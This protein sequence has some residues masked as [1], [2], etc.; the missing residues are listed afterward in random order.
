MVKDLGSI[1]E[2][3]L[4]KRL[5]VALENGHKEAGIP[6]I[7][8]KYGRNVLE[9]EEQESFWDKIKEQFQDRTVRLLL[10]AAFISFVTSFAGN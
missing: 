4:F 2:K 9:E 5:N 7:Q 3:E 8:S 1:S 10:I 6:E